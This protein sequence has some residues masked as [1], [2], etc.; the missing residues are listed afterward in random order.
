[1][2]MKQAGQQFILKSDRLTFKIGL[3]SLKMIILDRI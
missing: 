1:M 3:D 2:Q